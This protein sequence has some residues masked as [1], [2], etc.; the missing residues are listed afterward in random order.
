MDNSS[1]PVNI[2]TEVRDAVTAAKVDCKKEKEIL[3]RVESNFHEKDGNEEFFNKLATSIKKALAS[4]EN[5]SSGSSSDSQRWALV[6][7]GAETMLYV[8][9]NADFDHELVTAILLLAS[10]NGIS[11][12]PV[13]PKGTEDKDDLE[14]PTGE[15]KQVLTGVW[16]AIHSPPVTLMSN[17]KT[18]A[19]RTA[20]A[21]WIKA[22]SKYA[23]NTKEIQTVVIPT[24]ISGTDV[25]VVYGRHLTIIGSII[26]NCKTMTETYGRLLGM[27]ME[28]ES[29]KTALRAVIRNTRI[30][31]K[32]VF[33]AFPRKKV[34]VRGAGKKNRWADEPDFPPR[35]KTCAWLTTEEKDCWYG[36]LFPEWDIPSNLKVEWAALTPEQQHS[37]YHDYQGKL[38]ASRQLMQDQFQKVGLQAGARARF[39]KAALKKGG[40]VMKPDAK[41]SEL[42]SKFMTKIKLETLPEYVKASFNPVNYLGKRGYAADYLDVIEKKLRERNVTKLP[43]SEYKSLMS[44]ASSTF[45]QDADAV[46]SSTVLLWWLR[47]FDPDLITK[48]VDVPTNEQDLNNK[49]SALAIE[50]KT[51]DEINSARASKAA[52]LASRRDADSNR[53]LT[54]A[55]NAAKEAVR[56]AGLTN[57]TKDKVDK[58]VE[59]AARLVSYNNFLSKLKAAIE[60]KV[61]GFTAVEFETGESGFSLVGEQNVPLYDAEKQDWVVFEKIS[62]PE[63]DRKTRVHFWY[64]NT[65]DTLYIV[66]RKEAFGLPIT[67]KQ[68]S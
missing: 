4:A 55:D 42:V 47:R 9:T 1:K 17:A 23:R 24:E 54:G 27:F 5:A 53:R 52:E 15:M 36:G 50:T 40:V 59:M 31:W 35:P 3:E 33:A 34:K 20:A 51:D 63:A 14:T 22:A 61:P 46:D 18:L 6:T 60:K 21:I 11:I 2:P 45:Y 43:I 7:S 32:K 12:R 49:F 30:S 62:V 44:E 68:K 19:D 37:R 28:S 58:R 29:S 65:T 48:I 64:K 67:K 8:P 16:A 57:A 66:L 39:I 41:P 10:H 38:R 13:V 26:K 56:E 25:E